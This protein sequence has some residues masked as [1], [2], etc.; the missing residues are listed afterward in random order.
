KPNAAGQDVVKVAAV[1]IPYEAS[2]AEVPR[3][4]LEAANGQLDILVRDTG[5][6]ELWPMFSRPQTAPVAHA[7]DPLGLMSRSLEEPAAKIQGLQSEGDKA[8]AKGQAR[9]QALMT[10]RTQLATTVAAARQQALI[11]A[12]S[13]T[14]DAKSGK[15]QVE[16]LDDVTP[17]EIKPPVKKQ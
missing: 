14:E 3:A 7:T 13:G 9:L 5:G 10:Q 16:K 2:P 17:G 1:Q 6:L 12:D 8:D 4:P 15:G 11:D